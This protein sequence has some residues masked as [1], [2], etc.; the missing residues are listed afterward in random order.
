[1]AR[2]TIHRAGHEITVEDSAASA[3]DLVPI[4]QT[5]WTQT[6]TGD[7]PPGPAFGFSHERRWSP[8][9]RTPASPKH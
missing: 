6:H 7:V 4:A 8:D 5:I 3:K 1:M 9:T 2:I